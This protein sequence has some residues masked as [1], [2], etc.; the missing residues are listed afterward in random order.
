[1]K[2]TG[3][4]SKTKLIKSLRLKPEMKTEEKPKRLKPFERDLILTKERTP[5]PGS[6]ASKTSGSVF[7]IPRLPKAPK[8]SFAPQKRKIFNLQGHTKIT[9]RQEVDLQD[10]EFEAHA[11]LRRTK[12]T[13]EKEQNIIFLLGMTVQ[14]LGLNLQEE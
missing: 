10:E 3:K 4:L 12:E 1:M 6:S 5:T 14:H 9:L 2:K 13:K 7:K 8:Y 11:S